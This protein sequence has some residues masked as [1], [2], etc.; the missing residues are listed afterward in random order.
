MDAARNIRKSPV[1]NPFDQRRE[2]ANHLDRSI[3]Q[4]LIFPKMPDDK[5]ELR[6]QLAR[7]PPRH[8]AAYPERLASQDAASTTPPP[9]AIGLP[10]NEGSSS[11]STEA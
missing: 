2:I 9:T 6:T 11:C 8:A 7:A 1:G 5:K 3:A 4:S 10:R